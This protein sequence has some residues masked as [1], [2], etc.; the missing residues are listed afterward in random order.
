[1]SFV[2]LNALHPA[3]NTLHV[4]DLTYTNALPHA[5]VVS[6]WASRHA[7]LLNLN[8]IP[9]SAFPAVPF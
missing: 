3:H 5:N 1:M 7:Q 9:S 2:L 6:I 4:E 8:S